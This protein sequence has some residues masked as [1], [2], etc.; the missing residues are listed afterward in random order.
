MIL[1]KEDS[2]VFMGP[3]LQP[4]MYNNVTTLY[5]LSQLVYVLLLERGSK[6]K[7][8]ANLAHHVYKERRRLYT[9]IDIQMHWHPAGG[10]VYFV[11]K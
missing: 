7:V 2:E 10:G 1:Q 4:F 11:H 8:Q 5:R 9:E 6:F 3:F